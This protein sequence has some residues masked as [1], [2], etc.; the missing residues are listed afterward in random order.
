MCIILVFTLSFE[1]INQAQKCNNLLYFVSI[2]N[3]WW[4]THTNASLGWRTFKTS[5]NLIYEQV[6]SRSSPHLPLSLPP[7]RNKRESILWSIWASINN[8][9][10][11]PVRILLIARRQ[12]LVQVVKRTTTLSMSLSCCLLLLFG[13]FSG[14]KM[15]PNWH[16]TRFCLIERIK[17]SVFIV[18]W[19]SWLLQHNFCWKVNNFPHVSSHIL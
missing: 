18:T 5:H 17:S 14:L 13:W 11:F 3:D 7:L 15:D 16:L 10:M 6:S 8:F 1:V 12:Q 4:S 2:R 9:Y 19:R